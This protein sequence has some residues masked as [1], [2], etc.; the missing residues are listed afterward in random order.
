MTAGA[1]MLLYT[2]ETADGN[3]VGGADLGGG[4]PWHERVESIGSGIEV[5]FEVGPGR[6][7][8][9][10]RLPA[11]ASGPGSATS[12]GTDAVVEAVGGGAAVRMGTVG[13]PVSEVFLPPE[14]RWG[15]AGFEIRFRAE[16]RESAPAVLMSG[17]HL[18]TLSANPSALVV[19]AEGRASEPGSGRALDAAVSALVVDGLADGS[20][21]PG[22]RSRVPVRG[23]V[24]QWRGWHRIAGPD[25]DKVLVTQSL[26]TIPDLSAALPSDGWT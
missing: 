11:G 25:G 15:R 21:R 23:G 12:D 2:G 1:P 7:R 16:W 24:V 9:T 8:V 19:D 5:R 10:M 3:A 18:V 6:H 13:E 22:P 26:A 17:R 14:Y 4:G 20:F